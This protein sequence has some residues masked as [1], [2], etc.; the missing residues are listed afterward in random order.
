MFKLSYVITLTFAYSFTNFY[1]N[2]HLFI[3]SILFIYL[4]KTLLY[5]FTHLSTC[6]IIFTYI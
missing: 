4:Y 1:L 5:I 3:Y 2:C 6:S